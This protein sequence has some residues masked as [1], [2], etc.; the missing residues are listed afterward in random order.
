MTATT[1][2]LPRRLLQ[3]GDV[4]GAIR[5]LQQIETTAREDHLKLQQVAGMYLH[6]GQ[7]LRADRCYARSVELQPSNPDYLYNL[8]TSRTALGQLDE[9]EQLF[10]E[11]IRLNPEDYGAW[12]NRSALRRQTPEKIMSSN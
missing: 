1:L 8:A 2:D 9:A 7:H 10:T 5:A 4:A 12:L 11:A 6:C 3:D